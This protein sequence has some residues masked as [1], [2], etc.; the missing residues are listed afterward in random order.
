V[1]GLLA[2]DE[3]KLAQTKAQRP[4]GKSGSS[5]TGPGYGS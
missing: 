2:A 5:E 1:E 4:A 3:E